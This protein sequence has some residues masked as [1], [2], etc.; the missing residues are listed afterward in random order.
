DDALGTRGAKPFLLVVYM[1]NPHAPY[2]AR[3]EYGADYGKKARDRYD[4]EITF[5]DRATGFLVDY[6]RYRRAWDQTVLVHTSDHGEE[7]GEHGGKTHASTCHRE[8]THVPLVVRIPKVA[9]ARVAT[10]VAL[11]DVV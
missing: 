11:V 8:S 4:A 6:L 7:F 3:P 2:D 5:A 10:P 1:H 9:A